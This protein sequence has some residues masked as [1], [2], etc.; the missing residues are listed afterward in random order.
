MNDAAIRDAGS[1]QKQFTAFREA[2]PPTPRQRAVE[3]LVDGLSRPWIW[4]AM[5][6]QDIRLRYRGSILGPFWLTISMTVMIVTLGFL[7][8]TLFRL[9][10]DTYLP[11]LTLGLLFWTFISTVIIEGCSCFIQAEAMIRQV[12][13]SFSTQAY[14]TVYRNLIVLAH[15]ALICVAVQIYFHLP[16]S[17]HTMLVLPGLAILLL[18]GIWVCLLLGM[19]CARFRDVVPIVGSLVQIWFFLTPIFWDRASLD[20]RYDWLV[21]FNPANAMIE[22]VR[23]PMMGQPVPAAA[24]G[25]ASI[26]MLVG[27]GVTFAFFTRFRARI[28]FWV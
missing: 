15:N 1:D 22:I 16:L 19:I 12:K 6:W 25:I 24:W 3:D 14:R 20:S 7:Y 8:S 18:N 21:D 17:A 27:W 10:I 11:F 5:A 2:G 13:M 4:N 26:V 9:E 23:A 28:P